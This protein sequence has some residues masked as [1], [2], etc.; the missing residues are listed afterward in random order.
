MGKLYCIMGKSA[1]GKDTIF[2]KIMQEMPELKTYLTYTTRPK[3]EFEEEGVNYHYVSP[4]ILDGFEAQG[5][6]IE[7]RVYN[8]IHGPW[9]YA[10]VDD[11]QIDLDKYSYLVPATLVSYEK[12]KEYFGSERTEPIYIEVEDGIR[13]MRALKREMQEDV[14]KYKE[15]C[16]RFLADS[17]DF[18]EDA[19]T[20]AHIS[21]RYNNIDFD[22]CVAEILKDMR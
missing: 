22:A 13:L 7:K 14:P 11:G 19:L 20:R 12:L 6:L 9:I 4:E 5:K 15:L 1:S 3:R 8:T 10:T 16:R 2:S 17:E 18:S 21:K